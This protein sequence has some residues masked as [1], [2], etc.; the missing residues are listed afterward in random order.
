MVMTT[1]Q[2][3]VKLLLYWQE[4]QAVCEIPTTRK[5][6]GLMIAVIAEGS[7]KVARQTHEKIKLVRSCVIRCL[8]CMCLHMQDDQEGFVEQQTRTI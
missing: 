2:R 3:T 8:F 1:V 5:R 6:L 4:W 7:V